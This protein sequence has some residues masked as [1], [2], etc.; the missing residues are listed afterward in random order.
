MTAHGQSELLLTQ[1]ESQRLSIGSLEERETLWQPI[2]GFLTTYALPLR[3]VLY[4]DE[5]W[6]PA[7]IR[8]CAHVS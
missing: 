3:N 4:F 7:E 5:I 2:W 6:I 8:Q 1:L